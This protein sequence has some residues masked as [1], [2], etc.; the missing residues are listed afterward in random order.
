MSWPRSSVLPRGGAS[1]VEA[2]TLNGVIE[3]A[4]NAPPGPS[5]RIGK[6]SLDPATG[7]LRSWNMGVII[8]DRKGI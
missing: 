4:K 6:V 2:D 3:L 7:D 5:Y 1:I 8:K